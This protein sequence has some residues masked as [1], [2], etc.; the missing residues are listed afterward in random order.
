MSIPSLQAAAARIAAEAPDAD[1]SLALSRVVGVAL[2]MATPLQGLGDASMNSMTR[3]ELIDAING[4]N[5][6]YAAIDRCN[7]SVLLCVDTAVR[8]FTKTFI[9]RV[10]AAR[11]NPSTITFA[12]ELDSCTAECAGLLV[13]ELR[14]L[15][16]P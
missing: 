15:L 4:K 10:E 2:G 13:P 14:Q 6:V 3:T 1:Q 16:N 12:Q 8:M 11:G 5:E 9:F 7:E